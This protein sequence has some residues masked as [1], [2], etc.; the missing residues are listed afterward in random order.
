MSYLI[1][2]VNNQSQNTNSEISLA[3]DELSDVSGTLGVDRYLVKTASDWDITT[4]NFSDITLGSLQ[5]NYF[6]TVT[7]GSPGIG[8]STQFTIGNRFIYRHASGTRYDNGITPRSSIASIAGVGGTSSDWI[9]SYY[10]PAGKWLLYTTTPIRRYSSSTMSLQWTDGTNYFGCQIALDD[11][12]KTPDVHVAYVDLSATTE[13]WLEVMAANQS[14]LHAAF[15]H[16]A[17]AF[18]FVKVG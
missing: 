14:Y 12:S 15:Q 4:I 6:G 9:M 7:T 2:K 13:I 5:F 8:S 18:N 10:V 16:Q 11:S 17:V 1:E 3:V